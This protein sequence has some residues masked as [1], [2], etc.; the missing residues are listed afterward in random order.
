MKHFLFLSLIFLSISIFSQSKSTTRKKSSSK[1]YLS[2][3]SVSASQ[4]PGAV[5]KEY[6]TLN[7]REEP[8]VSNSK[9]E[10]ETQK[11]NIQIYGT[12]DVEIRPEFSRS[13]KFCD[14]YVASNYQYSS[15][16]TENQLK[17]TIMSSFVVEK[18][19]S[20][21]DIKILSGLS[22]GTE[23][24]MLRVFKSMSNWQPALLNNDKVRCLVK[25]SIEIDATKL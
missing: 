24:E 3:K 11:E 5:V 16:M 2:K 18:D 10:A 4:T 6:E 20:L 25:I 17:G 19:G 1:N 23:N 8:P 13:Q 15:E 12:S 21:T 9:S 22:H 7:T 14:Q